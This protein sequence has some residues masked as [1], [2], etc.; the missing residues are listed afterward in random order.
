MRRLT[1]DNQTAYQ[2]QGFVLD[3]IRRVL[4]R[5]GKPIALKPKI[6]DTLLVLVKNSGRVMDKDELMQ[7]VWPDTI[8][9]EVNLAHNISILRKVLGQK[10]EENRFIVTVPGRGYGF[11]AEVSQ[12]YHGAISESGS[13]SMGSREF[14]EA[15]ASDLP[16]V[17]AIPPPER[18]AD[19]SVSKPLILFVA[20]GAVAVTVAIVLVSRASRRP[21][22]QLSSPIKSIA[23]LPF[24]PLIVDG[25]DESLE[26]GIADTLIARLSNIKEINVRP[27]GAVRKYVAL[28]QDSAQAG[29][30]QRVDAVVE[31]QIQRSD[32]KIRVTVRLVRVRDEYILLSS[33]FDQKITDIFQVED[34]ISARIAGVLA[35]QLTGA[36]MERLT[37]HYTDDADAYQLYLVGRFH[38][39][40]LTDDGFIKSVDY[41]QRAVEKDPQFALAYAGMADAYNALGGFNVRPPKE[42]LPKARTAA[43]T[44]LSLDRSL[45][46]AHTQLAIVNLTFDWD[47]TAAN[48]EF[49][50][51][52]EINP[53]DSDAHYYYAY[54]WSFVGQQNNAFEEIRKAQELD[55]VSL[56]KLT[57]VA[58]ILLMARQYDQSIVES[59]KALEM[60]PNLG[61]AHWL[62]GLA[63][64]YKAY[65]QQGS[66][67]AAVVELQ[68]SVTLSGDSADEPI[69]LAQAYWLSGKKSEARKILEDL[70]GQ[71][72]RR[73][74]SP[75][76]LGNL[77]G[78]LG[79]N[80]RA[81]ALLETAYDDR[82]GLMIALKVDPYFDR[83]RID[84]RFAKL[85][86]RVGFPK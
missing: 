59:Q 71:S 4:S 18:V 69:T 17:N 63:H 83:L 86:E 47:W 50:R 85:L 78:V 76:A 82:D 39:N 37:K 20:L 48:S 24:K 3:P 27:M 44:A 26:M 42:V 36:E 81:F 9:E 66:Y 75:A 65:E 77:H 10:S 70:E 29:R 57:G 1:N 43:L 41:F 73:Y 40:R 28:D 74:I 8:V 68:K 35:P 25:R 51:A 11:V 46:Q 13:D 56:V 67:D 15:A 45:G 58:Q 22:T 30:E 84:P 61:F 33:Q 5:D 62:L 54:Y 60:D 19:K 14:T 32:E 23:V 12:S 7:Q 31:G 55:P 64:M 53:G 16:T 21:D 79:E 49:Q 38:A 80:D 34:S 72:K 52:I 2:F 6:F